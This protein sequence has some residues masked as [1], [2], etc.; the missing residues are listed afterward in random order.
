MARVRYFAN[1]KEDAYNKAK[2]KIDDT[3]LKSIIHGSMD[4]EADV[5]YVARQIEN[6]KQIER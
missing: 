5:E 6:Q 2:H 4:N 1:N 3:Q